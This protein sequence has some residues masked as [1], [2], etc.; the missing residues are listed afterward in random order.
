MRKPIH[1]TT[2]QPMSR[3]A[4]AIHPARIKQLNNRPVRPGRYVLY[5]MQQSQREHFNHALEYAAARANQLDLPLL[6]AFSLTSGFPDAN[7][8]HY[9]FMLEGLQEVERA[10]RRRRIK[11]VLQLGDP[12]QVVLRLGKVAAMIVCDRGYL[13]IQKH[14]R[15]KV[16]RKA[17]CAVIQI[18]SDVIVPVESASTKR[19]FAARTLRPKLLRLVDEFARPPRKTV[20]NKSSLHLPARSESLHDLDALCRRLKL[21]RSVPPISALHQGGTSV[22]RRRFQRFLRESLRH[23]QR[24]RNQPQTDDV[25]HM[26]KYLHFGQISPVWLLLAAQKQGSAGR[27]NVYTF[28][29]ELL[30]RRE[31]AA[32]WVEFTPEYDR[33]SALPDWARATL[34]KHRGDR[35]PAVYSLRDLEKAQTHDPYWNAA[36]REMIATGYLHNYMRM[37]WGKKI[38]EWSRT[39]EAAF[40]NTLGL[41]NKYFVDG[42]DPNGFANVAWIFGQHDRPWPERPIFGT[43]RYMNAAG[44][45]RKCDIRAYVEKVA[46]LSRRLTQNIT[47]V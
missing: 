1:A 27:A 9:R 18:E 15:R 21:D 20:V 26:S 7:L 46:A 10:L 6:V 33:Y 8:R 12:P 45:E 38:L 34:G 37:Y 42:R 40:R 3:A 22:A 41:N 24:H 47:Q 31:L 14:W 25:S 19:E 11:F 28:I 2:L 44:L 4:P 36:M 5:W 43:V 32:N 16:A 17:A 13:R 35:R 29:D 39:P 30:V 23:Y